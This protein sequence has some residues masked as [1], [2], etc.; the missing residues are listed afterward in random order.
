M[1]P[2]GTDPYAHERNGYNSHQNVDP[3]YYPPQ[4]TGGYNNVAQ[5][6]TMYPTGV[7]PTLNPTARPT[8][9]PTPMPTPLP[10]PRPMYVAC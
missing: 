1:Y 9:N 3:Y 10:T 2:T 4:N 7:P 5:P 6:P 8:P